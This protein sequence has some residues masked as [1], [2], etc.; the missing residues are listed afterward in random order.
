MSQAAGSGGSAGSA[1]SGGSAGSAGSGGSGGSARN[2]TRSDAS[3]ARSYCAFW[4]GGQCYGLEIGLV[5]EL[6]VV[7]A[8]L[9]VPLAPPAVLGLFSLR[10]TPVALV[11]LAALLDLPAAEG[12]ASGGRGAEPEGAR[13]ALV[14]RTRDVQ[15]GMLIERMETVI[16]SDRGVM[17]A[18][19]GGLE[20]PL[21]EGL[22]ETEQRDGLLLRVLNGAEL[23]TRLSR[24]R[25]RERGADDAPGAAELTTSDSRSSASELSKGAQG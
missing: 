14:L 4:A 17:R 8:L 7:E 20:D 18:P 24:L 25:F 23:L 11:D 10:G 22:F 13:P 2:K 19:E 6:T 1:G 5:G 12:A 9:P 3:S 15:A 16:S 21:I